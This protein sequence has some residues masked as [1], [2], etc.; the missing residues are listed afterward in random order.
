MTDV[1]NAEKAPTSPGLKA[2]TRGAGHP[3]PQTREDSARTR[4]LRSVTHVLER[5]GIV[6]PFVAL[7]IVLSAKS[8]PFLTKINMVNIFDQQA[9]IIIIGAGATLVLIA[10]GIDLSVGATYAMAAVVAGEVNQH[11]AA[12]LAVLAALGVG[13][14]IGLV[15]GVVTSVFR[16]NS[17]IATLAV[18]FIVTGLAQSI[19]K[20][21]V[22]A[23]QDSSFGSIAHAQILTIPASVWI[24]AL[25]VVVLGLF[26][27]R[28]IPGRY[29]YATGG[30]PEAARLAGVR[31]N[32][33]RVLTFV[34]SGV[35]AA[36]A[37][38]VDAARVLTVTA[39]QGGSSLTFTVLAALVVGGTSLLGGEGAVWRTVVGVLFIALIGNGFDL[40][41]VDPL[42]QQIFLGAILLLAVGLDVR[43][44]KRA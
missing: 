35:C 17:L 8:E 4:L 19:T 10:G 20:G 7:F 37:G 39:D 11:N 34:I 12:W 26:L 44:S 5:L 40:M 21:N 2:A 18:S 3:V 42:Y 14:L 13:A 25:L 16:I 43:A 23:I 38:C 33:V 32:A 28:S 31:I 9:S 6:I 1:A 30:G 24:A 36:L 15:N 27:A 29:I 41:H 22:I